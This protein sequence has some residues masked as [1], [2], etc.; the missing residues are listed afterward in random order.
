MQFPPFILG[1]SD[2]HYYSWTFY[3]FIFLFTSSKSHIS[4]SRTH[5]GVISYVYNLVLT[6]SSGFVI[7]PAAPP[8]IPA[9]TKYQKW[10]FSRYYGFIKV[11]R[12]SFTQTTIEVYGIFMNTVIGYERYNPITPS[13]YI[14]YLNASLVLRFLHNCK[15]CFIT[16][17]GVLK[18]SWAIVHE[19][20]INIVIGT[21][22]S[23]LL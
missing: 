13:Y 2:E 17:H 3:F 14:I 5:D 7:I 19:A 4:L 15:R 23:S 21:L 18:K 22:Y 9:H 11:L 16:S 20:P 6:T 10:G 1:L 8:A 12:F